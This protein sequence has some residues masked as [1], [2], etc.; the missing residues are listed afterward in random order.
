MNNLKN[1]L[2]YEFDA[3]A[4][5]N[6]SPLNTGVILDD[7]INDY[8]VEIEADESTL[9]SNFISMLPN[10]D[11]TSNPMRRYEMDGEG[12]SA[13]ALIDDTY[14]FVLAGYH[15]QNGKGVAR[16][17]ITGS[18]SASER[19]FDVFSNDGISTN[20]RVRKATFYWK[21]VV[22]KLQSLL[23]GAETSNTEGTI[24]RIYKI[25]KLSSLNGVELVDGGLYYFDGSNQT[26]IFTGLNGDVDEEYVLRCFSEF[27]AGDT[28]Y[29]VRLQGDSVS[30]RIKQ[31]LSNNGGSLLPANS[32][33]QYDASLK[34]GSVRIY[35]KSGKKR[36]SVQ[37]SSSQFATQQDEFGIWNPDTITNVTSI[38]VS[39][40]QGQGLVALFKRRKGYSI[41]PVPMRRVLSYS[42][43]S[44]FANGITIDDIEGDKI[45]GAIKIEWNG[46]L[47]GV[48]GLLCRLIG[49]GSSIYPSAFIR[50]ISGSV[51]ANSSTVS[52]LFICQDG[53]TVNHGVIYIYPKSG[54]NRPT[55]N[56]SISEENRIELRAQSFGDTISLIDSI[57]LFAS[58]NDS[59]EGEIIVSVP[60][61]TQQSQPWTLTV[62]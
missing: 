1:A 37:S 24:I 43:N 21:D 17:H 3:S 4:D 30:N 39:T 44:G 18:G 55:I 13:S 48:A 19:S 2:I 54:Q 16:I 20:E 23:F 15:R 6:T 27:S 56:K 34:D 26:H 31:R 14:S 38:E 35:A 41:D 40:T 61:Q 50:A 36:L 60:K 5:F 42:V 9:S 51:S 8:F 22:S 58:N 52:Q 62:N 46:V 10:S 12:T 28:E 53:A 45:P 57:T 59:I 33:V 25:P 32:T 29:I 7:D 49:D 47:S 11:A